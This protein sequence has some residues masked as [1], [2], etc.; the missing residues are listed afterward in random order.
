MISQ[1]TPVSKISKKKAEQNEAVLKKPSTTSKLQDN[2][3]AK[4]K[5]DAADKESLAV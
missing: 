1:P 2:D 5:N 4:S 3:T